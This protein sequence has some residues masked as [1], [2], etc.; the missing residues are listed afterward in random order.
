MKTVVY[1]RYNGGYG[2]ESLGPITLTG[3]WKI[4]ITDGRSDLYLGYYNYFIFKYWLHESQIKIQHEATYTNK[5][6]S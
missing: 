5:C 2:G 1:R 3:D 4:E 6:N